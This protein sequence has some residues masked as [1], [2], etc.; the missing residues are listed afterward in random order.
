MYANFLCAPSPKSLPQFSKYFE[1]PMVT[2]DAPV[3]YK[4]C[5]SVGWSGLSYTSA[6]KNGSL[7]QSWLKL[8]YDLPECRYIDGLR[9]GWLGFD[10]WQRQD[11]QLLQNAQTHC[12]THQPPIRWVAWTLPPVVKQ[13][14]RVSVLSLPSGAMSSWHCESLIRHK[15]GFT[16]PARIF[17]SSPGILYWLRPIFRF[18]SNA[19]SSITK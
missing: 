19:N 3:E 1:A 9:A 16:L 10:S 8:M 6:R 5:G 18:Y 4:G 13:P 12:G 17:I 14:G 7:I 15:D 11:I 2:Y